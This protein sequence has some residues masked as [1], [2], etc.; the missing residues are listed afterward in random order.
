VSACTR[1]GGMEL[2]DMR[3]T[4]RMLEQ[5]VVQRDALLDKAAHVLDLVLREDRHRITATSE[6]MARELWVEIWWVRQNAKVSRG[7]TTP[8]ESAAGSTSARPLC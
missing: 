3:G 6:R 2:Q 7:E 8:E 5:T 1:P 4:I